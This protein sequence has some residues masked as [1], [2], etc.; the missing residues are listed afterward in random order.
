MDADHLS[1][2]FDLIEV[3]SVL[4]GGFAI[5]GS[6]VTEGPMDTPL[7]FF[8]MAGGGGRLSTDGI[9]A[10]IE[11]GRG[12]VVV[13]NDRS[14]LRLDSGPSEEP[15][16]RIDPTEDF[17]DLAGAD[18]DLDDVMI[19]GR[20]DLGPSG[21]TLL[22]QALPPVAHVRAGG[23]EENRMGE[24]L[25]RL[26]DE[27]VRPRLGADFAIRQHAQLFLL[28]VFRAYVDQADLQ[29]GWLNLLTDEQL[30]P[31]V[32]LMHAEPGKPWTLE[33]LA[34]T[35]AMSRTA[36]VQRFRRTAGV[37]P[38]AYLDQW[39]ML[40]AQR[41]L[42]DTDVRIGTLATEL[43]YASE[44]A[45]STAFKRVVGEAPLHFRRRVSR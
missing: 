18:R 38:R 31:A 21:H 40:R 22:A 27:V 23:A 28:E 15:R 20:I 1:E 10:P 17:V 45:F 37:P 26:F 5:R 2:I 33:Q 7:K 35:A 6:W 3:R 4:T 25:D 43:G 36:F 32:D 8:A 16:R 30:R 34:H 42:H 13:L 41:A 29:P 39:R 14:F 44:S 11:L 9:D 12:D 19:G 24:S